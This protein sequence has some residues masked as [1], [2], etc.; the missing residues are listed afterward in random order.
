MGG[1]QLLGSYLEAHGLTVPILLVHSGGGSTTIAEACRTPATLA[2][3]AP[4][5]ESRLPPPS[6]L[7]LGYPVPSHAIWAAHHSTLPL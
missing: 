3:L 2:D 1:I 4:R 5:Q 7:R 6:R